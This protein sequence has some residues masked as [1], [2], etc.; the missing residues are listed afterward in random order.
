ME[1]GKLVEGVLRGNQRSIARAIT[2]AENLSPEWQ[3]VLSLL[4]PHTGKAAIIGVTGPPGSGKSTLIEKLVA[5]LRRRGKRVGVIAVDPT[6]PFTGGAFLGDRVRMMSLSA[7]PNVFIRSMAT[8]GS[9]GGLAKASVDAVKILDASGMDVV[10]VETIGAGQSDVDIMKVAET[11]VIVQA[12]GLGDEIQAIKAGIMEIGDIFVV[13]KADRPNADKAVNDIKEMLGLKQEEEG[14]RPPIIKTNALTGEGTEELI[15][16]IYDHRE[17]LKRADLEKRRRRYVQDELLNAMMQRFVGRIHSCLERDRDFEETIQRILRREIDS[18]S[19]ADEL[20]KKL[21]KDSLAGEV[22]TRQRLKVGLTQVYTGK[23]KG[24]TTAAFGVALRAIGRGLKVYMIQF[25]KGGFDYGELY[26]VDS[27]SNFKLAAFGR[28]KFIK[29]SP[30]EADLE[31]AREA[32]Q[33]AREVVNGGE[34]DVVI[35]DEINVALYL[36]LVQIDDVIDLIKGKPRHVELILT[37]RY[38]PQEILDLADLVTE[39]REIKHPFNKGVL[40]RRGIEY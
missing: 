33:T 3:K 40:A 22:V 34:Y 7:D 4:Y 31:Q 25:I 36:G 11:V 19:A 24:K 26:I 8:R 10:I 38:A 35:L 14:W 13:N 21:L 39:M 30:T 29:G 27:L 18:Y 5:E 23:G 20:I 28:G 32:F 12:P 17:W 2:L 37:G 15:K 9:L 16:K 1:I 6:S